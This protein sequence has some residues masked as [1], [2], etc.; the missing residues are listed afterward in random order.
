M[1][2]LF[3]EYFTLFHFDSQASATEYVQELASG[4]KKFQMQQLLIFGPNHHHLQATS[5]ILKR[6]TEREEHKPELTCFALAT[7]ACEITVK[8]PSWN[9][10]RS[11]A[12]KPPPFQEAVTSH[13]STKRLFKTALE[14]MVNHH[15]GS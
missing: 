9:S 1:Y 5:P 3:L 7:T 13:S 6:A 14:K 10:C 4:S 15:Q 11:K 8:Q 12:T 2:K